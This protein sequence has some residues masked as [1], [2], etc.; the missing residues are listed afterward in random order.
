MKVKSLIS[1]LLTCLILVYIGHSIIPHIHQFNSLPSHEM[2]QQCSANHCH[3][4][5]GLVYI[6][7]VQEFSRHLSAMDLS[8]DLFKINASAD[9][10]TF[11]V[12]LENR[13]GKSVNESSGFLGLYSGLRA[14]PLSV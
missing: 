1:T 10:A 12:F 11:F 6:V 4:F 13:N 5:N 7:S 3:A 2:C 14:P 9:A 8:L